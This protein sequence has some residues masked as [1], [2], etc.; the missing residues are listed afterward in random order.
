MTRLAAVDLRS[1][2]V[3]IL[4]QQMP[5]AKEARLHRAPPISDAWPVTDFGA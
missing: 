5:L 3:S 4:P 2:P 1:E